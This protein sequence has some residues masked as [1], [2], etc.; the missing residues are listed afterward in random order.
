MHN[1]RFSLAACD[2]EERRT[3]ARGV[4]ECKMVEISQGELYNIGK[5]NCRLGIND[6]YNGDLKLARFF[7]FV[8]A[9]LDFFY[10]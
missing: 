5:E 7:P 10:Y 1:L 4:E 3:I 6:K 9:L 8:T 2:F